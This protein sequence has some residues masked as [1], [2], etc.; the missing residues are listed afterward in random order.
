MDFT[1]MFLNRFDGETDTKKLNSALI[2]FSS[3]ETG[4]ALCWLASR[5]TRM[6]S[7]KSAVTLLYFIDKEEQMRRKEEMDEYQNKIIADIMPTVERDKITLRLFILPSDNYHAEIMRISEEQNANLILISVSSSDFNPG[8]IKKL[9][10]LK[11]DPAHSE[12]FILEQ[13]GEREAKLLKGVNT[14]FNRNATPTGL[15]IDNGSKE[16][17]KIFVPILHQDDILIFTYLYRIA[18]HEHIKIMIW[19]AIGILQSDPKIQKFYQFI[20]K[21]S[22]GRI[23]LWNNDKKIRCDFIKEQDL[24]IT[25]TEGWNKLVC[26]PLEWTDCLPSTLIIKE[27]IN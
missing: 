13:F 21:K 11:N 8:L 2:C 22:D 1:D 14:I 18:Q 17:K 20:V 3:L 19:D 16:F 7:E 23:Y 25:G 9:C 4:K 15:Y 26:T 24:L 27:T 5:I 6:K 12:V 10:L